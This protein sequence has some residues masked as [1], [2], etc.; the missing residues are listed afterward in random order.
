M[1]INKNSAINEQI[2]LGVG[3]L[4][5]GLILT[6]YSISSYIEYKNLSEKIDFEMIDN[7]HKLSSSDKYYEYLA[8]SEFLTKKLKKNKDIPI[9]NL[10]CVYL[11]YAQ[12]NAIAM[13]NLVERKFEADITKKSV[14]AGNIRSL[15]NMY[16]N[17]KICK[18]ASS[19]KEE[20]GE[21]IS[22]IEQ[23]D[24]ADSDKEDRMIKFVNAPK[25]NLREQDILTEDNTYPIELTEEQVQQL[26]EEQRLLEQQKPVRVP[27]D[28][29]D[30][31]YTY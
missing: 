27:S 8:I 18:Q 28:D 9:K 6:A 7:N 20:L 19:L 23:R 15:Y 10:S 13:Y 11:D 4:L 16:D 12:H 30:P 22:E 29:P 14:T 31:I 1:N 24:K 2:M 25:E 26:E 5:I 21:F 17:Y 3:I